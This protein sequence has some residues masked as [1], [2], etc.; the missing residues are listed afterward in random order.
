MQA[1]EQMETVGVIQLSCSVS[2]KGTKWCAVSN[3]A[4]GAHQGNVGFQLEVLI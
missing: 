1:C 2:T 4:T 3:L